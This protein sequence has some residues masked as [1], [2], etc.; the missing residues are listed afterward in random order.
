VIL[1]ENDVFYQLQFRNKPLQFSSC[2][3]LNIATIQSFWNAEL[4]SHYTC[5][6]SIFKMTQYLNWMGKIGRS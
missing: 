2:S 6:S 3:V 5:Y 4:S 1:T